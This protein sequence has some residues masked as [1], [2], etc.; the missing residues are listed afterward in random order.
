MNRIVALLAAVLWSGVA[1]AAQAPDTPV[2]TGPNMQQVPVGNLYVT[3]TGGT[4]TTLGAA[5]ANSTNSSVTPTGA[6]TAVPLPTIASQQGVLLDAFRLAADT[7][8]TASMTRAVAAGVPI[9][10]GPKTYL[11]HD[12]QMAGI[13][14]NFVLVGV[15][16][17]STIQ[18]PSATNPS[19]TFFG[20]T[21]TNVTINGVTFDMNSGSVSANQWGVRLTG[22]GQN[23]SV[24]NSVFKNN[25]GAIG[26]CFTLVG[27]GIAGGGS[28]DFSGNEVTSCSL[29]AVYISGASNGRIAANWVHDVSGFGIFVGGNGA[30]A[31]TDIVIDSNH[32]YRSASTG[33][34]VGGIASPFT[35]GSPNAI[36][37]QVTN[38]FLQDNVLYGI[39]LEGDY[40]DAIGNHVDQ[41]SPSVNVLGAI[42]TLARWGK[43]QNNTI[44]FSGI[45]FA[46]D[47]G[48]SIGMLISG[49]EVT[50]DQGSAF[51]T[52]GNQNTAVR[53]NIANLSGTAFGVTNYATEGTGSGGVF[54]TVSS[55][56]VVENNTFNMSA[57]TA[58][59]VAFFDNSG[60]SVGASP[61][62]IRNN[63]FNVSGSGTGPFQDIVWWGNS[64]S[65]Q[66]DGNLHNGT[67]IAFQDPAANG[68]TLFDFVYLGGTIQGVSSTTNVRS[69]ETSFINTYGAGGSVLWTTP[70]A[71]GTGYTA[72]TVINFT[73]T[74][75]T[76]VAGSP[77][78]SS[79][80]IIGVKMSNHGTGCSG[81]VTAAASDSGGGTGATFTVG[82]TP[83]MPD[84]A[85][86]RYSSAA[87]HVLLTGG[88]FYGIQTAAPLQLIN[89]RSD[90]NLRVIYGG[91]SWTLGGYIEPTFAIGSL[92]TCNAAA[93]GAQVNVSGSVSGKWTARCNATNWIAPDGTTIN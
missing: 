75:C 22:G 42:D 70:A 88:G 8:D 41:S 16:G 76:S 71:G 23:V 44:V 54:P 83:V 4:Q 12:Y 64:H 26:A 47:I 14:A 37:V 2:V 92:P 34:S 28:F 20:I 51:N 21:A 33:I 27:T 81:A 7:D 60:A 90:V 77:A 30:T 48:G 38:N 52:G 62:S 6:P 73:G 17:K 50:M 69:I 43:I 68:D 36:H 25:S 66:I 24:K 11:I 1:I 46:I 84:A 31:A 39:S 53:N 91:T 5:L 32:V 13:P 59:G 80:V 78:I 10:L 57:S 61:N 93:S 65:V 3:P 35:F 15:P 40:C 58:T 82:T 55:A 89:V 29:Q 67:N 63:R 56:T 72:A 49:N 79:G 86:L 19:G 87:T 74:G 45:N 85:T 18:R 9:L